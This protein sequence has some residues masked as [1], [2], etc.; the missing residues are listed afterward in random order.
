MHRR[1]QAGC[2]ARP[3]LKDLRRRRTSKHADVVVSHIESLQWHK[4]LSGLYEEQ[5]QKRGVQKVYVSY[6]KQSLN[7]HSKSMQTPCMPVMC[8]SRMRTTCCPFPFFLLLVQEAGEAVTT[9][10]SSEGSIQCA[11]S[12]ACVSEA[13][14][15]RCSEAVRREKS[16]LLFWNVINRLNLVTRTLTLAHLVSTVFAEGPCQSMTT[17]AKCS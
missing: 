1:G 10:V 2:R 13:Y 9:T 14:E 4:E 6:V 11:C 17:G 5:E 15:T 16:D 12:C 8:V 7:E 3:K